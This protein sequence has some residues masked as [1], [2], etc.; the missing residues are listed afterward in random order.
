MT[1]SAEPT[2]LTQPHRWREREREGCDSVTFGRSKLT[3]KQRGA[4]ELAVARGYYDIGRECSMTELA[5]TVGIAKSTCS[6][7]LH[8]A[9]GQMIKRFVSALID[10]P[11]I[12][13]VRTPSASC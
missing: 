8:R 10:P 12:D 5:D 3:S 4:L 2:A 6:E 9:E 7:T 13:S 11:P 1:G